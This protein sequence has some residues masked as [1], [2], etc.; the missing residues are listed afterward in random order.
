MKI[1][2]QAVGYASLAFSIVGFIELALGFFQTKTYN[3][4]RA[5]VY[6]VLFGVGLVLLK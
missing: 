1:L 4:L 5:L 2:L 6:C 3:L